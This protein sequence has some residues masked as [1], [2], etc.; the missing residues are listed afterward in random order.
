MSTKTSGNS[1]PSAPPTQ[2]LKVADEVW[3]VTALLHRGY[4]KRED[5]SVEE[6]MDRA[7]KESGELLRPGIR[8]HVNQHC[9]ANRLPNPARYRMLF[10]TAPGRRRLFKTG[11]TYHP[12]REGAKIVPLLEELPHKYREL[13]AWYQAWDAAARKTQVG[14]DPILAL[15]GSGKHIWGDENPDEYVR[16]LREGWE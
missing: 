7:E 10:E 13:L 5:F 1:L 9:V 16:S 6:I 8:V 12:A 3:V 14:E 2:Q 11:D 4:P 15:V